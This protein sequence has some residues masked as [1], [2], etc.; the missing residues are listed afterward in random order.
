MT[1][2]TTLRHDAAQIGKDVDQL[3]RSVGAEGSA[4]V[5]SLREQLGKTFEVAM[6]K[7]RAL[8]HDVRE[9]ATQ[10]AKATDGYVRAHPWQV[11]GAVA[12]AGLLI[13]ALV[14]RR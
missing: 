12:A 11:I 10:T 1:Q 8:D 9:R 13:G 14:A 6:D 5:Q 3:I 7:A 4:H 2:A